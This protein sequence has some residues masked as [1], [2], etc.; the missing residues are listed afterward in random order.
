MGGYFIHLHPSI[1]LFHPVFQ[2][3]KESD[4]MAMEKDNFS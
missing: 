3:S 4:I 1:A 2:D